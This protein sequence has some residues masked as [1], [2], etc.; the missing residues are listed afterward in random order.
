MRSVP[1]DVAV[2]PLELAE[3]V[4]AELGLP[5]GFLRR[6]R[7]SPGG[8]RY[9]KLSRKCITYK[10]SDVRRWLA[11]CASREPRN[12]QSKHHGAA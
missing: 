6:R 2:E 10:L 3:T 1:K 12:S 4:E 8:P 9:Y 7:A 11:R 5:A